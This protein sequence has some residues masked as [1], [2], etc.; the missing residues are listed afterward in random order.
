MS[1]S[2]VGSEPIMDLLLRMELRGETNRVMATD[3]EQYHY[4]CGYIRAVESLRRSIRS[5]AVRWEE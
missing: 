2:A 4:W 1:Y 5:G 3:R